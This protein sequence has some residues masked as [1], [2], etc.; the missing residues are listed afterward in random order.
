MDYFHNPELKR[1]FAIWLFLSAV[2]IAIGFLVSA[3]AGWIVALTVAVLS[4]VAFSVTAGRYRK[5]AKLNRTLDRVLHGDERLDPAEFSEGEL[6]VL[7]SEIY[8]MTLML[9]E[10]SDRLSKDKRYLADALADISHQLRTP[11]TSLHMIAS[12]LQKEDLTPARRQEL[13]RELAGLLERMDWLIATL[14]KLSR[15]D[16][17]TV[18]FRREKFRLCELVRAAFD[19]LA[20]QMD[21]HDLSFETAGDTEAEC[22]A[23]LRWSAE[24]L[25]NI[26]KNCMEHTPSGG[27]ITVACHKTALYTELVVSDTGPG[28]AEAD[29][30]HLFER[31]YKGQ[32]A[33]E[34]GFGIGLAL[35]RMILSEQGGTLK[36]YNGPGG[37]C[38]ELRFYEHVI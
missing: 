15:L 24:A 12:F 22:L 38:F 37:A 25:G 13:A 31:F 19:P 29:L 8:K 35:A 32:N 33:S 34:N 36:A 26:L 2:L 20:I 17:G 10:R 6:S 5:I 9:R 3:L 30:P 14:L 23:D 1:G 28:I 21:L 18:Q 11:L 16:A 4:I 27:K 7:A